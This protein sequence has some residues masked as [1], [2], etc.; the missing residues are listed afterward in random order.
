MLI[1]TGNS[2]SL[3]TKGLFILVFKIYLFLEKLL[4]WLMPFHENFSGKIFRV[5]WVEEYWSGIGEIGREISSLST[6]SSSFHFSTLI[7]KWA[8]RNTVCLIKLAKTM[9]IDTPHIQKAKCQK[10]KWW[11]HLIITIKRGSK[12]WWRKKQSYICAFGKKKWS[13]ISSPTS[14]KAKRLTASNLREENSLEHDQ[15]EKRQQET[16]RHGAAAML[17][18]L[19]LSLHLLKLEP[20][21]DLRSSQLMNPSLQ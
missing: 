17:L 10:G 21:L 18:V 11:L 1:V 16:Q 7:P 19:V 12:N 15:Y 13:N 2:C 3:W 6:Q 4:N 5:C 8:L 14:W 9:M 20:D